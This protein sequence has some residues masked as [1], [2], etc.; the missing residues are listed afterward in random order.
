M[1][2]SVDDQQTADRTLFTNR[3]LFYSAQGDVQGQPSE[4]VAAAEQWAMACALADRVLFIFRENLWT[5]THEK[6]PTNELEVDHVHSQRRT[7]S[8]EWTWLYNRSVR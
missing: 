6:S 7:R 2:S 5:S 8:G 1:I 3:M 4:P